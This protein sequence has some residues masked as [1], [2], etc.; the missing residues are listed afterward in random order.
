MNQPAKEPSQIFDS[1]QNAFDLVKKIR[2]LLMKEDPESID[3]AE[4]GNLF[5]KKYPILKEKFPF[6]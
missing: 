4:V 2:E 6:V 5:L 3:G 1:M